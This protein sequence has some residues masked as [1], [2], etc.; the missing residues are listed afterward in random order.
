MIVLYSGDFSTDI[1]SD[2]VPLLKSDMY[3][4]DAFKVMTQLDPSHTSGSGPVTPIMIGFTPTKVQMVAL[5]EVEGA[6]HANFISQLLLAFGT[7]GL[8]SNLT[9]SLDSSKIPVWGVGGALIIGAAIVY[10]GC[11]LRKWNDWKKGVVFY[12]VPSSSATYMSDSFFPSDSS[13]SAVKKDS[14]EV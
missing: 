13:A 4:Q 5:H 2:I 9:I 6:L 7:S 10:G 3:S 12:T 11:V 8:F 14:N 1:G